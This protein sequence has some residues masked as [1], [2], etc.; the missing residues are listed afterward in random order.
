MVK[1]VYVK[2]KPGFD[3]EAKG[4]LADLKEKDRKSVV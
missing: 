1:R 2:K 4:L 3:V